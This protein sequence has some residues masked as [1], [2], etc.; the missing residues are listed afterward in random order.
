QGRRGCRRAGAAVAAGGCGCLR[1]ILEA[2]AAADRGQGQCARRQ[3]QGTG[4]AMSQSALRRLPAWQALQ[5]HAAA[6]SERHLRQLF[7]DDPARGEA[8]RLEEVGL[9]LDYSKQRVDADTLRLLRE[10]A[11]A[12]EL[13]QR[14]EAMFRGE[15]INRTEDRAVLDRMAE[16]AGR[17]R[18]GQW[19]GHTG[20]R[21]R[22]VISIGI[23][24]SD[25]GPVMAYE[26]L[27]DY[28]ER[29]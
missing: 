17:V 29:A 25:L 15:R 23:G 21:I 24:G 13:P 3:G 28:R 12:C 9:Y 1:Q 27:R 18:G 2:V 8:F 26:A 16:F 19:L 7:A 5:Q 11:V 22:N 14:T 4:H 6:M 10:L 20:K